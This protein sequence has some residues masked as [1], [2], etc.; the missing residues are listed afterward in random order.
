M[1]DSA[2]YQLL[3]FGQ[4]RKL[5][6]FG[7]YAIDRVCPAADALQP[8]DVAAWTQEVA[9]F[10]RSSAQD[11]RWHGRRLPR[12]WPVTVANLPIELRPTPTGQVG[13]FPEQSGNWQWLAKTIRGADRPLQVLNLFAYTGVATLVCAA[14]GAHVVH[15]DAAKSVVAWARRNAEL[16]GLHDTPIR[17]LVEDARKFVHREVKRGAHYDGIILDPP[18]YGHGPRG[19]DWRIERDLL[20]L[21]AQ[22]AQLSPRGRSFFLLSCHS[23]G[24]GPAELE[25]CLSDAV[26][27]RCQAGAMAQRLWLRDP[28][29]RK[30]FAGVTARWPGERTEHGIMLHVTSLQNPRIKAAVKLRSRR[31][32]DQQQRFL[33]HGAREMSMALDARVEFDEVFVCESLAD[34][35]VRARL[36]RTL[37]RK[38]GTIVHRHETGLAEADLRRPRRW[39]PG[40]GRIATAR[41]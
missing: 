36:D 41:A 6:R 27:G 35:S 9:R 29:G 10:S 5:E 19:Q 1:L 20:P 31:G 8:R 30:L 14:A 38:L 2:V 16:A 21:L 15:V 39:H 32:R 28:F 40:R 23:P 3:D 12:A 34:T 22:C 18:T 17:W 25:A 11:G 24:F 4:G 33:I 26:L 37:S 13:L 7:Q